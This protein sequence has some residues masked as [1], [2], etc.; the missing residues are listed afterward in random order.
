M[1]LVLLVG[2]G[3]VQYS[4]VSMSEVPV[5]EEVNPV[6]SVE[7]GVVMQE[8]SVMPSGSNQI[9]HLRMWNPVR[10]ARSPSDDEFSVLQSLHTFILNLLSRRALNRHL[11]GL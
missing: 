5:E 8:T 10:D 2:P 9:D 3:L 1:P 7:S 6:E 11:V 4:A